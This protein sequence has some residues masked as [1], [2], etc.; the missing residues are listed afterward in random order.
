MAAAHHAC[1]GLLLSETHTDA[2]MYT[3]RVKQVYQIA[4]T[5]YQHAMLVELA[6]YGKTLFLDNKIQSALLDEYMFHE[7]MVQPGIVTHP[8][9]SVC[10]SPGAVREPPYA[11]CCATT[12]SSKP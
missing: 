9:P 11:R 6:G 12:P 3:Y 4:Q 1:G 8:N 10:W 7:P 2:V 5:K